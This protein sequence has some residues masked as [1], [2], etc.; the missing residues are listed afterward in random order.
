MSRDG[1]RNPPDWVDANF[2]LFVLTDVS[3]ENLN[4]ILQ[5]AYDGSTVNCYM[6]WLADTFTT[7]PRLIQDGEVTYYSSATKPPIPEDWSSPFKGKSPEDA[8]AFLK[9]APDDVCV[10]RHHFA[11][12]GEDYE[13]KGLVALY[14][15]GDEELVGGRLE[16][17]VCSVKG[18]TLALSS[19]E[20]HVWEEWRGDFGE[21]EPVG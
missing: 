13:K 11:V 3:N 9:T 7:A 20:K 1:P 6:F 8:A 19:L 5:D 10:D 16:K 4:Q 18:S 17:L 15:I 14:R 2:A 21:D 12:L